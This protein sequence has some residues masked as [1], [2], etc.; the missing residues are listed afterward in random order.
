MRWGLLSLLLWT[1]LLVEPGLADGLPIRIDSTRSGKVFLQKVDAGEGFELLK[2][3]TPATYVA[4]PGERV[5][6]RVVAQ[7]GFFVRWEG[8][9]QNIAGPSSITIRLE[10]RLAWERIAVAVG[11]GLLAS[12]GLLLLYRRRSKVESEIAQAQ[13]SELQVRAE[14]AEQV[15]SLARRLGQYEVLERLGAGA[16]GVVYKVKSPDGQ[17][18]AAKV[19]NE[20]DDRVLREAEVSA[21]LKSPHIVE[22]FGL[23]EGEPDFLLLEYIEGETLHSW[24]RDHPKPSL[25]EIDDIVRQLLDAL[26]VA[27]A[28]GVFHR[29]IKPE[30][31]FWTKLQGQATLKVMDFG[32]AASTNAAR[33][34]RTGEAMGTPVYASPEQ[35]SG[36]PVEASTDLY[37][38]GVLIYE[39]ATGSVP[40]S[41]SDP[42]ALTLS[43][44]KSLPKEP[45]QERQDLPMEWNQLVVDLL[46]GDPEKRPSTVADVELRWLEGRKRIA[47]Y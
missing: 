19:P 47:R 29:D 2:E 10:R 8:N 32:L 14:S 24:L 38:V 23:V 45:I 12:L 16:M 40:W 46:S 7:D 21:R 1:G 15:G 17:L 5:D 11:T 34:T 18:Y 37:S 33:L 9:R 44:Y 20:M 25:P 22:C 35:L 4:S 39:L 36:N 30:N 43:K 27:H 42:V 41:Q 13:I 31:L 6:I 26:R 28:Q 3:S